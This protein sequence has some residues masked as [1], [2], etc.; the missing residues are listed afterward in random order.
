MHIYI[1]KNLNSNSSHYK[2]ARNLVKPQGFTS[3]ADRKASD[4][5]M[6]TSTKPYPT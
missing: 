5:V 2:Y 6:D 3:H 1:A 4:L